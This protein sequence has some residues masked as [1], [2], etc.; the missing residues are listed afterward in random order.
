MPTIKREAIRIRCFSILVN[1]PTSP[2][3]LRGG[4][5]HCTPRAEARRAS[6]GDRAGFHRGERERGRCVW[7]SRHPILVLPP[8]WCALMLARVRSAV[9]LRVTAEAGREI[10]DIS[11]PALVTRRTQAPIRAPTER[12]IDTGCD[13]GLRRPSRRSRA[14]VPGARHPCIPAPPDLFLT[15]RERD[16]HRRRGEERSACEI[17][18]P[19]FFSFFLIEYR[20]MIAY[21]P[22]R[23]ARH[24]YPTFCFWPCIQ[25]CHLRTWHALL[26]LIVSLATRVLQ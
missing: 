18:H 17:C 12:V 14:G 16:A 10:V 4:A 15:T 1:S 2:P 24:I 19:C 25:R 26:R 7:W 13:H 23:A 11:V 22:P 9:H 6:V 8:R 3:V 20:R 5:C 21:P